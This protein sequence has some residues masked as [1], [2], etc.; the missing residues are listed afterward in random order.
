ME[1]SGYMACAF[2]VRWSC[3]VHCLGSSAGYKV[4]YT[5]V[6]LALPGTY[7]DRGLWNELFSS[8]KSRSTKPHKTGIDLLNN[9]VGAH[10]QHV[11]VP[12]PEPALGTQQLP[13]PQH[14]STSPNA[15]S[16]SQGI[17]HGCPHCTN[18][19]AGVF[20]C[21]CPMWTL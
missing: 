20:R 11:P 5:V 15:D 4:G 14:M 18:L 12:V 8:P 21:P 10:V 3:S 6:Q 9:L 7:E 2:T 17:V 13:S 1:S 19:A 16:R